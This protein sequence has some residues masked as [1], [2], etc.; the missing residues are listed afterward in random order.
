MPTGESGSGAEVGVGLGVALV[1]LEVIVIVTKVVGIELNDVGSL[2]GAKVEPGGEGGGKGMKVSITLVVVENEL[3][4]S[5]E[6]VVGGSGLLGSVDI[7]RTVDVSKGRMYFECPGI[8]HRFSALCMFER[9]MS[10]GLVRIDLRLELEHDDSP[11][12]M[13]TSVLP[14]IRGGER[15]VSVTKSRI[16]SPSL[17]IKVRTLVT[18]SCRP[19]RWALG[20]GVIMA[21]Q[22]EIF[23]IVWM[24]LVVEYF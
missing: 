24:R 4:S 11:V 1:G 10:L 14:V 22:P 18:S 13:T 16:P 21:D 9:N 7:G 17:S 3:D 23:A 20:A 5:W 8:C 15:P 2:V 12:V 19:A 6:V